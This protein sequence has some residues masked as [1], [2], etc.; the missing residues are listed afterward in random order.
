[1]LSKPLDVTRLLALIRE[2]CG[3]GDS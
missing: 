1:V 3:T 2:H